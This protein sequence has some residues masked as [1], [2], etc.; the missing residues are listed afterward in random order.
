MPAPSC[1]LCER[2]LPAN[3]AD[4]L[5]SILEGLKADSPPGRAA[6][7]PSKTNNSHLAPVVPALCKSYDPNRHAAVA[8]GP[9]HK[10][11]FE[12][13][14]EKVTLTWGWR[15]CTV[16]QARGGVPS[17]LAMEEMSLDDPDLAEDWIGRK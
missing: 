5:A 4:E 3:L 16:F 7:G 10:Y 1:L 2:Q 8:S 17:G 13:L 14:L 11:I 9:A 12:E 15:C 6:L